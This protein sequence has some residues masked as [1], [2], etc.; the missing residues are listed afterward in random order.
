MNM[1]KIRADGLRNR[2]LSEMDN[3]YLYMDQ[4]VLNKVCLGR[5]EYLIPNWNVM[6]HNDEEDNKLIEYTIITIYNK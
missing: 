6:P 2:F 4:D 1:K 3:G 5:V